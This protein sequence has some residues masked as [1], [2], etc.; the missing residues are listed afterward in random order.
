MG[1]CRFLKESLCDCDGSE[2]GRV[3]W[4][5]TERLNDVI[6]ILW[7][8]GMAGLIGTDITRIGD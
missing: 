4:Y 3:T 8:R 6:T 7:D 2:G 5:G 1:N